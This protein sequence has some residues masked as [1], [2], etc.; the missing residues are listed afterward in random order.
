M[1]RRLV[2]REGFKYNVSKLVGVLQAM[3]GVVGI[4]ASMAALAR[5]IGGWHQDVWEVGAL[6]V[7]SSFLLWGGVT[8][9]NWEPSAS[10]GGPAD[11]KDE[12]QYTT[13]AQAQFKSGEMVAVVYENGRPILLKAV[14]VRS[15]GLPDTFTMPAADGRGG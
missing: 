10:L 1:P 2:M 7:A 15:D 8:I 4:A 5:L 13:L 12:V 3:L 9:L 11:L 14:K 6:W